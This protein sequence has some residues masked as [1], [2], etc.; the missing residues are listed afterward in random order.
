MQRFFW[1]IESSKQNFYSSIYDLA[2]ATVSNK[3]SEYF[4]KMSYDFFLLM[5]NLFS[6]IHQLL[7]IH[8]LEL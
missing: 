3:Y 7:D 6:K 5:K 2:L 8:H 4:Y 1:K